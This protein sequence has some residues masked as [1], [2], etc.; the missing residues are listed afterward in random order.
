MSRPVSVGLAVLCVAGL[1]AGCTADSSSTPPPD[2]PNSQ[3]NAPSSTLPPIHPE[4]G[5]VGAGD[6]YYPED[7]NGGY[8]VARY[9]LD[10]TY[11][12]RS[13]RLS[14]VATIHASATQ[15]LSRF[16]LDFDG[17]HI[18]S[19]RV[20]HRPARWSRHRGE[21]T[22]TPAQGLRRDDGFVTRVTYAGVPR[23]LPDGFGF[24]RTRT[25]AVVMGEPHVASVWFPVN[26]HPTD[27]AAYSLRITVPA[28]QQVVANG[29]LVSK[30]R[31]GGWRTWHWEAREPMAS[32]LA[33]IDIGKWRV[34]KHHG[35]G[36]PLYDAVDRHLF[37]PFARPRT[38]TGYALS[39]QA[40]STYKRLTDTL[41]VP[42]AGGRLSFWV[43]RHTEDSWDFFFVE[44]RTA[45]GSDWT[46][47][48]DLNGHTQ[49][50]TGFSCPSWLDLHPF[51]AHYETA[52][53]Q[54]ACRPHG[55]TGDW[56]AATGDSDGYEH[57]TVDLA[58]YAGKDVEISLAVVSDEVVQGK[59]V[60]VDDVHSTTGE[61]STSFEPDT[62]PGDGWTPTGPPTGSPANANNWTIGT[63]RDAGSLGAN[64][65]ATLAREGEFLDFESQL[66]GPYPFS[67]SGG[68]VENVRGVGVALENQTRPVYSP[69]FFDDP[70]QAT[71]V[72]VHE[73]AHQWTGDSLSVRRWKNVWLNEGFAT[74]VEWLWAEHEH[75]PTTA[76]IFDNFYQGLPKEFYHLP[77]GDPGPKHL[78]DIEVYWRGAM[79]LEA[80]RETI[81]D[82]AFF[83]VLHRWTTTHA[84]GNVATSQFVNLAE[85]ISGRQ[86]DGFFHR[87]L[88]GHKRPADPSPQV[89][90]RLSAADAAHF[91]AKMRETI[92]P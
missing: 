34:R 26:D 73:L 47:L 2:L 4:P 21:L 19:V 5:N 7:G 50:A 13:G 88:L 86:L 39:Q 18:R 24:M 32:Y 48:P 45:G 67:T 12:P 82:G 16:D 60:Y 11:R 43:N 37:R 20:D 52:R 65:E 78:F 29:E 14:G 59:G 75:G 55:T 81:G 72:V 64:A 33:T 57:W 10:L 3:A 89:R 36:V 1:A 6:P 53:D 83:K 62:D 40:S 23:R 22:V 84:G 90:A 9:E 87:W 79:T 8:D 31:A 46:T 56:N 91:V 77:I 71:S 30:A 25:T 69:E 49:P 80:L 41:S 92:R 61:G 15:N 54:R 27:K 42:A 51:L 85:R 17:M 58:P 38:G 66:F 44:A 28:R 70:T 76:Q 35:G 74:Y 63:A 68:I